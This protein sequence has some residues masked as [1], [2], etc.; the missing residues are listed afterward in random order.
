MTALQWSGN[1]YTTRDI[2]SYYDEQMLNLLCPA[3][4][5]GIKVHRPRVYIGLLL[6]H[7]IRILDMHA[8]VV[9]P[10][11]VGYGRQI[12]RSVL[13][14]ATNANQ[15]FCQFPPTLSISSAPRLLIYGFMNSFW[16]DCG[17]AWSKP[18][19]CYNETYQKDDFTD[20][21]GCWRAGPYWEPTKVTN[22]ERH[23]GV[24]CSVPYW[25]MYE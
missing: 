13:T 12:A 11:K 18:D 20:L 8:F 9:Q 4:T 21:L 22:P 15:V 1:L 7:F 10:N 5:K 14:R 6:N 19:W 25:A 16:C 17:F 2:D 23:F 24:E 3:V